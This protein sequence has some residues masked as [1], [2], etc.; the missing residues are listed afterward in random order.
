MHFQASG[1]IK[2]FYVELE[3]INTTIAVIS[4]YFNIKDMFLD[5][6]GILKGCLAVLAKQDI[7][8]D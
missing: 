4:M 7:K 5:Q 2:Y 1:A 3:P 6:W 8:L